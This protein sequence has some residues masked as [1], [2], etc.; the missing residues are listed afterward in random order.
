MILISWRLWV[1]EI[2]VLQ[3]YRSAGICQALIMEMGNR[4]HHSKAFMF[5]MTIY[6]S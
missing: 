4:R 5:V 6:T 2:T 1:A 3:L